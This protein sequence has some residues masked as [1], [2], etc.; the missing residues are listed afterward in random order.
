MDPRQSDRGRALENALL[1]RMTRV[2]FRPCPE[3]QTG[4]NSLE[5]SQRGQ[6]GLVARGRLCWGTKRWVRRPESRDV[7]RTRLF[8]HRLLVRACGAGRALRQRSMLDGLTLAERRQKRCHRQKSN[9]AA[10]CSVLLLGMGHGYAHCDRFSPAPNGLGAMAGGTA[11]RSVRSMSDG[12]WNLAHHPVASGALR[13]RMSKHLGGFS[14]MKTRKLGGSRRKSLPAL[15][16]THRR[17]IERKGDVQLGTMEFPLNDFAPVQ[18][19]VQDRSILS[20]LFDPT[21]TERA[22]LVAPDPGACC[23]SFSKPTRPGARWMP[24]AQWLIDCRRNVLA[25]A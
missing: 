5:Q 16:A 4:A 15:E 11:Q 18:A 17:S 13:A 20:L 9:Q 8:T 3:G 22:S 7:K 12:Q 1:S 14:A 19:A 25:R 10:R 21:P 2:S 6:S 24:F 23:S